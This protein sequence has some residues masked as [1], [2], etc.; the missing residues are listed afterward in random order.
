[1]VFWRWCSQEELAREAGQAGEGTTW[2]WGLG[3]IPWGALEWEDTKEVGV[4]RGQ[5]AGLLHPQHQVVVYSPL[6]PRECRGKEPGGRCPHR[7]R[8]VPRGPTGTV[9]GVTASA[10][11]SVRKGFACQAEGLDF[12]ELSGFK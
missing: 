1:M 7:P 8:A 9:C 11:D 4:S 5:G 6:L 10:S 12:A 2:R 3:L